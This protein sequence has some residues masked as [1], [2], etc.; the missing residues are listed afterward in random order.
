MTNDSGDEGFAQ[1]YYHL[2][3]FGRTKN[4]KNKSSEPYPRGIVKALGC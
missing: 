3:C 2:F 1:H 4:V